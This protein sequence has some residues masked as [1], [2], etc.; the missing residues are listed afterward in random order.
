MILYILKG[1][2]PFKMHNIIFFQNKICVPTT[3]P[4]IFRPVTRKT[5]IFL[6]GLSNMVVLFIALRKTELVALLYGCS[7]SHVYVYV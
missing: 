3:L 2:M 6:F 4:K 5:F 7:C 1:E